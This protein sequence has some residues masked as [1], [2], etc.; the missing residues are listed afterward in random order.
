[1]TANPQHRQWRATAVAYHN[2]RPFLYGLQQR[3]M[4]DRLDLSLDIPSEGGRKLREGHVEL[5]LVP[6]AV[7]RDLPNARI[8]ADWCIGCDGA[9]DTVAVYSNLPL[10]AL[11]RIRLDYHSM[12]SVQL[13]R[14]LLREHW[15]CSPELVPAKPGYRM[16]LSDGLEHAEGALVIG[17][18]TIGLSQRFAYT[19]DLGAAWKAHTGLPFVFAAWATT[20]ALPSEFTEAFNR[21][22]AFGVEH[23]DAVV[24]EYP[25]QLP[26]GFDLKGYLQDRISYR[27]DAPKR[28][29]LQRY[30][31]G[32]GH[33][34]AH[35]A[36]GIGML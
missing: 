7:L 11:Q 2:T 6:V 22:L 25:E 18:R 1:M 3:G 19:Y 16:R 31:A 27:L 34:E 30:L 5:G 8:I 36:Q 4:A 28:Q 35:F 10:E 29:A 21:A 13:L 20:A 23:I 17:D 32:I 24:E 14:L 9:V 12:T 15:H 33:P 26:K